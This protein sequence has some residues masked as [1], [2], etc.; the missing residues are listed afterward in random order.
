MSA[1]GKFIP[2]SGAECRI[3]TEAGKLLNVVQEQDP[4]L[5]FAKGDRVRILTTGADTRVDKSV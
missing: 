3:K 1:I 5:T 4:A 2:K